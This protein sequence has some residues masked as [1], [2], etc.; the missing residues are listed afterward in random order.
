MANE[1]KCQSCGGSGKEFIE[2]PTTGRLLQT[3]TCWS[4]NGKGKKPA[5]SQECPTCH[6]RGEIDKHYCSTLKLS[7]TRGIR[8]S[9]RV[10]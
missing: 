1:R 8:R 5:K 9:N 10:F 7:V 4:C 3:N 6:G 2:H